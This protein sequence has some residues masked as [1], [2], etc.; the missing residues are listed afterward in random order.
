MNISTFMALNIGMTALDASQQA[1]D[2]I[3]N[4]I[5]N[6]NTTGYTQE[7][8]NI[9]TYQSF[10]DQPANDAPLIAGQF[11]EGATVASVT[12]QSDAFFNEEDRV[13]QG[14]YAMFDTHN[15]VLTQIEG[16][17]NE[18][19][20]TGMSA[21]LDQFFSAY[22]ALSADP[23]NTAAREAVVSQA[24]TVGQTFQ[25]VMSEL[26]TLQANLQGV[27][28]TGGEPPG[29]GTAQPTGQLSELLSDA[30]QV[31]SLNQQIV[32]ITN[33]GQNP[34]TLLDQRGVILD[35][36]AKLANISYFQDPTAGGQPGTL[37]YPGWDDV[38]ISAG[39]TTVQLVGPPGSASAPTDAQLEQVIT[40]GSIAGNLQALADVRSQLSYLDSFL[41]NFAT[42]VNQI[43]QGGYSSTGTPPPLFDITTATENAQVGSPVTYS[44]LSV[45]AGFTPSDVATGQETGGTPPAPGNNANALAM[46]NL[47]TATSSIAY[48][49]YAQDPNSAGASTTVTGTFD[50]QVA[51]L[52][53]NLGTE[54]AGVIAAETTA[55]ALAQQTQNLRQSVSGVDI[56]GQAARMVQYQ[57][58][59]G[60]AAKFVSVFDQMLQSLINAF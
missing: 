12:R 13:N 44:V 19:S 33:A 5:A 35:N 2:V 10:P 51:T 7:T 17:I 9:D 15:N 49:Q 8:A 16:I 55:K 43:Q 1:E 11:G 47:Q 31:N 42:Q 40:S 39:G 26:A 3:G 37:K 4:N 57:N 45:P 38:Q 30:A 52:V 27:I 56:N 20:S 24:Q 28:G 54:T 29:G 18:P 32:S 36:M 22:Q 59:Y 21:E 53:S 14:N 23:T 6:A 25:T 41:S 34:N 50:Q 60:A 58:A 46:V 48:T